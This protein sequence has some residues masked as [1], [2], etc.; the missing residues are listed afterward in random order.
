MRY[1]ISKSKGYSD[2]WRVE[3]INVEEDGE[4]YVTLFCGALAQERAQEY[5]AWKTGK[6]TKKRG[7]QRTSTSI[8]ATQV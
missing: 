1:E 8:L 4:C 7:S 5:I 2:E 3:T 6:L